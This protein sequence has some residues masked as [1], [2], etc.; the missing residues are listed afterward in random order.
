[1]QH[2]LF[3]TILSLFGYNSFA[4][5]DSLIIKRQSGMNAVEV[6]TNQAN[7]LQNIA[8]NYNIAPDILA[9]FNT[10]KTNDI[11]QSN[12]NLVVPLVETNFYKSTSINTQ[13]GYQP[14]YFM[15]TNNMKV[16][17]VAKQ[18]LITE[19]TLYKWNNF[20]SQ[21]LQNGQIVLVGYLKVNDFKSN[22][23][24]EVGKQS[25]DVPELLSDNVSKPTFQQ[26]VQKEWNATAKKVN[27]S[28]TQLA[29][30][31][32]K[33]AAPKTNTAEKI[34]SKKQETKPNI[35]NANVPKSNATMQ[36]NAATKA[37]SKTWLK[38][39][40]NINDNITKIKKIPI[41]KNNSTSIKTE[42]TVIQDSITNNTTVISRQKENLKVV[43]ADAEIIN[44]D[45]VLNGENTTA[46]TTEI[47]VYQKE[48]ADAS[49]YLIAENEITKVKVTDEIK[50]TT[51]EKSVEKFAEKKIDKTLI[52]AA[53]GK[54]ITFY[55]SGQ[56]MHI[57]YSDYAPIGSMVQVKNMANNKTIEAK[58]I[59]ALQK[60][61]TAD[62]GIF[63]ILSDTVK[64][65]LE[66]KNE[67]FIVEVSLLS[68]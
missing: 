36:W 53:K 12:T 23:K 15:A 13:S 1:M 61:G 47:P 6:Y 58:I 66:P 57:A 22:K 60:N 28:M 54:A 40:A 50:R 45:L 59:G 55:A 38:T 29:T 4:A 26:Q 32:K 17:D 63:I 48:N 18:F 33:I 51:V 41:T 11:V 21:V 16:I 52:I 49:I 7:T 20:N 10:F 31:V 46:D 39:K 3:V 9:L 44:N 34:V 24:T 37:V 19:T 62:E 30:S 42:T 43:T 56:G 68:N 27:K 2:F 67:N 64:K 14:I 25:V 5:T 35:A 8:N 65:V